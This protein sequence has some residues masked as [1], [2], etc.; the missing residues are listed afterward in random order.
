MLKSLI[1]S[2]RLS[3]LFLP[4]FKF[5]LPVI[6]VVGHSTSW[7]LILKVRYQIKYYLKKVN[8]RDDLYY[9]ADSVTKNLLDDFYYFVKKN[10]SV[11]VLLGTDVAVL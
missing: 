8:L 2:V 10:S 1:I 3:N 4:E 5:E 7:Y 6:F 11:Q 9:P